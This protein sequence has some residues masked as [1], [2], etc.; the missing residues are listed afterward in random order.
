MLELDRERRRSR[1]D[2]PEIER[3]FV[4]T[5]RR[6]TMTP[7]MSTI[8]E[9]SPPSSSCSPVEQDQSASHCLVT[10]N[11]QDRSRSPVNKK[12]NR[13]E[14]NLS[15][16]DPG[17]LDTAMISSSEMDVSLAE[18]SHFMEE[19]A[20]SRTELGRLASRSSPALRRPMAKKLH[21]S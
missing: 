8:S 16:T 17:D 2:S 21:R 12:R 4:T 5:R 20:E 6:G 18:A 3:N 15:A 14:A 1:L 7:D 13:S 11:Q 10:S 19:R 9:I